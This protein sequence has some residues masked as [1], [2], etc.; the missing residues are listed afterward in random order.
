MSLT[1]TEAATRHNAES[2]HHLKYSRTL[3]TTEEL[4]VTSMSQVPFKGIKIPTGNTRV[5][6]NNLL[7]SSFLQV[8]EKESQDFASCVFSP[9]LLVVHDAS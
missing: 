9:S 6:L 1:E 4:S 8:L 2:E 7:V 5:H 3:C